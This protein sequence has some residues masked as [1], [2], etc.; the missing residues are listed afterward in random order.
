M[1]DDDE[2]N[3]TD[4]FILRIWYDAASGNGKRRTWRGSIIHV[5]SGKR[6]YFHNLS[7]IKAFIQK[8]TGIGDGALGSWMNSIFDRTRQK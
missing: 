3:D 7:S 1:Q 8:Q 2:N 6:I 5:G 4:S